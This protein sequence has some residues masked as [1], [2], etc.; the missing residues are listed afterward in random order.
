MAYLSDRYSTLTYTCHIL[1]A[2]YSELWSSFLGKIKH[3]TTFH[4]LNNMEST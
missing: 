3:D 2:R 4:T 1:G